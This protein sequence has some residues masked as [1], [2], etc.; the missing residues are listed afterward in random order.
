MTQI[1]RANAGRDPERL[2]RKY[3]A[4]RASPFVFLR[5]TCALFYARLP[6]GGIFKAAPKVWACG[7]MHRPGPHAMT[8]SMRRISS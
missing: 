3:R 1:Q 5:G 2:A 6:S 4:M 7:D 8:M